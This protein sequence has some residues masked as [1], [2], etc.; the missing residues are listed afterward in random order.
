MR[1]WSRAG[2]AINEAR[3]LDDGK[4]ATPS[5]L[6]GFLVLH[7]IASCARAAWVEGVFILVDVPDDAFFVNH[8][9]GAIRKAL[10]IVQNPVFP[11]DRPG[12]VT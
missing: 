5:L 7:H 12:E 10:L 3:P 4:S 6:A 2:H 11:G 8:K 1:V 9:R